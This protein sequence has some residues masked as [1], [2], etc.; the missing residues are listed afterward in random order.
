MQQSYSKNYLK[1]YFW[2]LLSIV[3]GF[4]SL[5]WVVPYLSD[6]PIIYGIYSVCISVSIFLSY[7]DLGFLSAGQKYAAEAYANQNT[8]EEIEVIGFS[9]F[10]LLV[11]TLLLGAVFAWLSF[12]PEI[13]IKDLPNGEPYQIAHRLLLIL[14]VFAPV[15][16][17]QR[18]VQMVFAI[19]LQEYKIQRLVILGNVFKIA[20][21][22]IFFSG[23]RYNIVAY[24][25][26]LQMVNLTVAI[27]GVILTYK[28]YRQK[29]TWILNKIKFS[30]QIF[31]RTKSLAYSTLF[32]TVTWILYYELDSFAIGRL[33]GAQQVAIY[34]IGLTLLSFFRS[35]YGVLFTPFISRFNHFIGLRQM[36]ELQAFFLH[37]VTITLPLVVFPILVVVMF[38]KS[39]VISWVGLDFID[40]VIIVRLLILCNLMAFVSYPVGILLVALKKVKMLYIY[41]GIM[42]V[43]YWGG[44]FATINMIGVRSFALFKLVIFTVNAVIYLI[45]ALKFLRISPG[46]FF[47]KSIFP[48][49]PSILILIS[50]SLLLN[51]LFVGDKN[52]L[53]LLYNSVLI[54]GVFIVSL[55]VS[56]IFSKSLR[57]YV[58]QMLVVLIK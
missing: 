17:L 4:L 54:G 12:H 39:F 20:S 32:A 22:F 3:L 26:F 38:S 37:V 14:A 48:Y 24:F 1:I 34:A 19:R 35:L 28:I 23:G 57:D 41:N 25:F 21:V 18:M 43:L 30:K 7:A 8:T 46:K 5:F 10:I 11:F 49:I 50:M 55:L 53:Y 33:L 31:N 36:K 56:Y 13:L 42:P 44:I 40:S 15:V 6:E 2:Q 16:V 51:D 29:L 47:V 58:N 9:H 45:I 52:K 27:I